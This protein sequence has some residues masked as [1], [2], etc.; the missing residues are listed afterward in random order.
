MLGSNYFR[1]E[2]P[3]CLTAKRTCLSTSYPETRLFPNY[4]RGMGVEFQACGFDSSPKTCNGRIF[5]TLIATSAESTKRAYQTPV[6]VNRS[7]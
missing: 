7:G 6:V 5:R 3:E 2:L 4:S 1:K